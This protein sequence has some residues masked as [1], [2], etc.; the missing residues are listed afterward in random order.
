MESNMIENESVVSGSLDGADT[1]KGKHERWNDPKLTTG[2]SGPGRID[3]GPGKLVMKASMQ[4]HTRLAVNMFRGRR[5]DESR[6]VH[7]IMGLLGFAQK[8][9]IVWTA[10]GNDDPIADLYLIRVEEAFDRASTLLSITT[11]VIRDLLSGMEGFEIDVSE[12]DK[13]VTVDM[14]FLTPWAWQGA[15]ILRQYDELI[16]LCLTARHLGLLTQDEWHQTVRKVGNAI[17]YLFRV[18][19]DYLFTGLRRFRMGGRIKR[20]RSMYAKRGMVM[21]KIPEEVLRLTRRSRFAPPIKPYI[22]ADKKA[23]LK[24]FL[25]KQAVE[26]TSNSEGVVAVDTAGMG[27][28]EH[29]LPLTDFATEVADKVVDGMSEQSAERAPSVANVEVKVARPEMLTFTLGTMASGTH[30]PVTR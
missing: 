4:L 17:R 11:A 19:Y 16:R 30:K 7:A 8:L 2:L 28:L 24:A 1:E 13:P 25:A 6:G 18:P 21:P 27:V 23:R 12:S 3:T 22:E 5:A 15:S 14:Y 20:A 10:A 26:G 9:S 29:D